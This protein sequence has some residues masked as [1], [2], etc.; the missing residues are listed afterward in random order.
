MGREPMHDWRRELAS[1]LDWWR[2]AGIDS[3][4]EDEPRDWLARPAPKPAVAETAPA[5][6]GLPD[7]L[8][9]FVAWRLSDSAPEADWLSARVG[10]SGSPQ[11]PLMVLTDMP[12]AEDAEA[13]ALLSGA[14]GRLFDRMLAAIGL[15]RGSV[16][17][18]SLAVARPLTGQIA[19]DDE[20]KLAAL[21]RHHIALVAPKSILFLG[22]AANRVRATTSGS[23]DGNNGTDIKH[24]TAETGAC[25]ID[26]PR[27]LLTR[28]AAKAEAWRNLLL[29]KRGIS[30]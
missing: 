8:D 9:A 15:E 23:G 4:V 2:E 7:T 11:A 6:A 22:Q 17:L 21:A 20:A 12:E 13:G 24:F 26:H 25:S 5:A 14:A 10:P 18:A 1:A 19:P 29:L 30:L 27:L 28:P 16:Y 3:F